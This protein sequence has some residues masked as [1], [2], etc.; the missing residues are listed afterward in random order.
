[1]TVLAYIFA[2]RT[3]ISKAQTAAT[4]DI[5][6]NQKLTDILPIANGIGEGSYGS[7]SQ[8]LISSAV[9]RDKIKNLKVGQIRLELKYKTSGSPTSG[10]VCAASHCI[11]SQTGDAWVNAVKQTNAEPVIVTPRNTVDAVNMLK[12]FNKETNNPV[13]RWVI[14]QEPDAAKMTPDAY[15]TLFNTTY[16]AMKAVDP[17][18]QIG[19]PGISYFN[20]TFLQT[21]LNASG[22]KVDFVDFHHY[23]PGGSVSKTDTQKVSE[24][25]NIETNILAVKTMLQNTASTKAR[26]SQIKIQI[27]EWDFLYDDHNTNFFTQANTLYTASMLGFILKNGG[28]S[29]EYPIKGRDWGVLYDEGSSTAPS[30][31]KPNDT[32]YSYHGI[33]MFGGEGLFRAFGTMA[34]AG[35]SSSSDLFVFASD[36]PRNIVVINKN[37]TNNQ[38]VTFRLN[39]VSSGSV[40][41][42]TREKSQNSLLQP[43]KS[44]SP[45][46]IVNSA[47]SYTLPPFSAVTFL[48]N[49]TGT[50]TATTTSIPTNSPTVQPTTSVGCTKPSSVAGDANCDNTVD[51]LDFSE[52]RNEFILAQKNQL[53]L[54]K[55]WA[56]FDKLNSVDLLDFQIFRTEFIK[57]LRGL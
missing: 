41:T 30:G 8:T 42:W 40:E 7:N 54:T 57:K 19:G 16:D 1:M 18:V 9:E 25:I 33:G 44:V 46:N 24:A 17:T 3:T 32:L 39:G 36:N 14:G 4:I 12:H 29:L 22:A 6:F 48:V 53:D 27:G 28:L 15:A 31:Y 51:L 34:V 43:I 11:S 5:D 20:A 26:A 55:A 45:I 13:K 38:A 37:P 35:V 56:N 47:F 49:G 50:P 10:I 23:G 21:F 52:F 2:A